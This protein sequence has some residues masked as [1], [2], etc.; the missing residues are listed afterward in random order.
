MSR[1][2]KPNRKPASRYLVAVD[3][4][5]AALDRAEVP[6]T[7]ASELL[8]VRYMSLD[9]Y[10]RKERNVK[11]EATAKKMIAVADILNALVDLG[12]LPLPA[13]INNRLKRP[14]TLAVV[15]DYMTQ[16]K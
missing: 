16:Y 9:K 15:R 2:K 8:D 1:R 14:A 10:L 12:H 6:L 13:E 5:S 3:I 11:D 7:V 4:L